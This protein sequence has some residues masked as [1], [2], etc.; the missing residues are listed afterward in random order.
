MEQDLMNDDN[1]KHRE[2]SEAVTHEIEVAG[3]ASF[4][5]VVVAADGEVSRTRENQILIT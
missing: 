3:L 2:A 1:N 4:P 5:R